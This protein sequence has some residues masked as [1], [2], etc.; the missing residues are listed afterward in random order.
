MKSRIDYFLPYF[1]QFPFL[2]IFFRYACFC[3][4]YMTSE[5]PRTEWPH[6]T[7]VWIQHDSLSSSVRSDAAGINTETTQSAESRPSTRARRQENKKSIQYSTTYPVADCIITIPIQNRKGIS[8]IIMI[9]RRQRVMISWSWD[10]STH[11][12]NFHGLILIQDMQ[13]N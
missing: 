7:A 10:I 8:I 2:C 12:K 4:P 5:F 11:F 6:S 13:W 3:T 1:S 9:L